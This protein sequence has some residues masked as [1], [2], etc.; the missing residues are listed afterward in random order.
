MKNVQVLGGRGLT[1]GHFLQDSKFFW[2]QSSVEWHDGE[3]VWFKYM[4]SSRPHP[5]GESVSRDS[6][7][8]KNKKKNSFG[9][10]FA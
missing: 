7:W 10:I 9:S 4:F 2:T 3:S 6:T 1:I 5:W 8:A